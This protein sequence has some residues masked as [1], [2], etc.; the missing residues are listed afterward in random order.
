MQPLILF[1]SHSGNTRRVAQAMANQIGGNC[2]EI[3]PQTPYPTDYQ[4]VVEQAKE[5]IK[6]GFLPDLQPLACDLQAVDT[7]F[8]GT[9]NWW[10]TM[11]P[12]VAAFLRRYDVDGKKIF[13]FCTHGGG[14]SARIG[15]DI[16]RACPHS[17]VA[18]PFAIYGNGG[19]SLEQEISHWLKTQ[20]FTK[21]KE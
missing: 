1:Y 3:L 12:P 15:R 21:N 13:S 16:K 7:L 10:S 18:E 5:E 20:A 2:Y 9:P 11:A 14:G 6:A 4:T 8:I 19:T 17:E